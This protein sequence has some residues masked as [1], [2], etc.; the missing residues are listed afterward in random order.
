M[1]VFFTGI[2]LQDFFACEIC[3]QILCIYP[4]LPPQ[5]SNGPSLTAAFALLV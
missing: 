2:H 5:I 1:I 4:P 3:A